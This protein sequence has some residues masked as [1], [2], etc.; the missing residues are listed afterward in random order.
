MMLPCPAPH[1]LLSLARL[2]ARTGP[3]RLPTYQNQE[4][5]GS[6]TAAVDAF[7]AVAD[8]HEQ[9]TA[10]ADTADVY[11][12]LGRRDEADRAARRAVEMFQALGEHWMVAEIRARFRP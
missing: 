9:A 6:L 11:A 3:P 2:L 5:L 1:P 8:Q 10:L 7:V 4:A 12:A